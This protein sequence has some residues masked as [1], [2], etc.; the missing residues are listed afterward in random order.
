M[1]PKVVLDDDSIKGFSVPPCVAIQVMALA[2]V[3]LS[4]GG[5][6]DTAAIAT[7]IRNFPHH[8]GSIVGMGLPFLSRPDSIPLASGHHL[9]F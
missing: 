1:L 4:G 3:G 6:V 5:W 2:V 9:P 8:R 7:S